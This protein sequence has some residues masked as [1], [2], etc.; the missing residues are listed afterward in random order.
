MG[1]GPSSLRGGQPAGASRRKVYPFQ[2]ILRRQLPGFTGE[3]GFRRGIGDRKPQFPA[4][5]NI[6]MV[7]C[8]PFERFPVESDRLYV[9]VAGS[10]I[11]TDDAEIP[12]IGQMQYDFRQAG[13]SQ[14]VFG[15]TRAHG[16]ES[17]GT[18]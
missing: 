12:A 15:G 5:E 13:N 7:Y 11:F 2:T 1:V 16:I 17:H 4:A 10:E 18:E 8:R 6:R 14:L 3:T 9:A